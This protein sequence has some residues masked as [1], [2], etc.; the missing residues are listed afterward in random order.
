LKTRV[1]T[2]ISSSTRSSSKAS[3]NSNRLVNNLKNSREEDPEVV[4]DR[5]RIGKLKT[6]VPEVPE[7]QAAAEAEVETVLRIP[8]A[9]ETVHVSRKRMK[10]M[11]V[12]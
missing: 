7:V 9:V 3:R 6:L 12:R 4:K 8:A 1:W 11:A 5:A 10:M 2:P